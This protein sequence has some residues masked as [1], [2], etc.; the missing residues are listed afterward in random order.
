MHVNINLHIHFRRGKQVSSTLTIPG[1]N[2]NALCV[3]NPVHCQTRSPS[4][5]YA[6]DLSVCG[7]WLSPPP[8]LHLSPLCLYVSVSL[9]LFVYFYS[10]LYFDIF[11]YVHIQT[12][13]C[14][15][16]YSYSYIYIY[17]A[18]SIFWSTS[19]APTQPIDHSFDSLLMCSST[20]R[21]TLVLAALLLGLIATT[22]TTHSSTYMPAYRTDNCI[23]TCLF[24]IWPPGN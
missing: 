4:I 14:L 22:G 7:C 2:S 6:I 18:S 5:W 23:Y 19:L 1:T 9:S 12:G 8:F 21:Q 16:L 15:Y 10:R 20:M 24:Y 3:L 11:L 17:S 13:Y